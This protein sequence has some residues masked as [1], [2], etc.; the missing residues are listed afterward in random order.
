MI[1]GHYYLLNSDLPAFLSFLQLFSNPT[2]PFLKQCFQ[3]GS[4]AAYRHC[5]MMKSHYGVS[6]AIDECLATLEGS[7]DGS[8]SKSKRRMSKNLSQQSYSLKKFE[9]SQKRKR[10]KGY[11][12]NASVYFDES[13]EDLGDERSNAIHHIKTQRSNHDGEQDGLM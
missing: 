4:V 1:T 2:L 9:E 8:V 3:V 7:E 13:F 5:A 12:L 11:S 6:H 10:R